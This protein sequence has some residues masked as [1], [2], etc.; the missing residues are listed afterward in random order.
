MQYKTLILNAAQVASLLS[1]DAVI[2]AV[3]HAYKSFNSG[4]TIMPPITSIGIPEHNGEMDFKS[5]YSRDNDLI[6][7]KIAGGFYDNPQN[8]GLSSCVAL[9]CL[10]DAA[11]G[12][13]VCVMDGSLI[14]GIRTGAAGA[15]AA[16]ALARK[17][18]TRAAILGTGGQARM[19]IQALCRVLPISQ[20]HIWGIE[21][22]EAYQAEMSRLLP[23]VTFTVFQNPQEAVRGCDI[24]ITATVSHAPL[25]DAAWVE[26]GMHI[27]AVGCDTPGKQEW[28]PK[29]FQRV[30]K[31]VNDSI[32]ECVRR[33]E[34]QHPIQ[35]GY[36]TKGDIYGEIG[37]ILLG[38]KPGR[39][40]DQEITMFD[41]TGL[42]ILDLNTAA[43]VYRAALEKKMGSFV[44][45]I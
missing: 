24:V 22:C 21:G 25:V 44:Q 16:R 45:I 7:M 9:I 42:S 31:L 26:P 40:S 17:N 29:V 37:E 4:K 12:V 8:Y 34:T 32:E 33:G 14:T 27:T 1:L 13:P 43:M 28:D 35:L 5:G 6:S 2:D 10:L 11:N 38:R 3:E 41:T 23:H 18:S 20:V 39:T 36:M 15:V 30:N 19:Q